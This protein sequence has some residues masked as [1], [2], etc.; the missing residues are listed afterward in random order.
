MKKLPRRYIG[1]M[2]VT[3][4]LQ[5]FC[6]FDLVLFVLSSFKLWYLE[7][8]K[9][10]W[11][12]KNKLVNEMGFE[13]WLLYH[14]T[15]SYFKYKQTSCHVR[16]AGNF[17]KEC[18]RCALEWY[19]SILRKSFI[20]F[21]LNAKYFITKCFYFLATKIT[22]RSSIFCNVFIPL[23]IVQNP[24]NRNTLFAQSNIKEFYFR[25]HKNVCRGAFNEK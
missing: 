12:F 2:Y 17:S 6:T 8:K 11:A 4:I 3:G 18:S 25:L 5:R 21:S 1:V 22:P 9:I 10:Q 14:P 20:S 7:C 15:S 23:I 19:Q 24:V 16:L 13:I